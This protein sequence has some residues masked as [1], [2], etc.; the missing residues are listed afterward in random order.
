ML[1][2]EVFRGG[3]RMKLLLVAALIFAFGCAIKDRN[4]IQ[5][6]EA[7]ILVRNIV[8][9]DYQDQNIKN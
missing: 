3:E 2:R 7:E 4:Y 8:I 5:L 1:Y 9:N 6:L